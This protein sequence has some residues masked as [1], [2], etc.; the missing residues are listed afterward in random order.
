[1]FA[2]QADV[3]ELERLISQY[4]QIDDDE[5][6]DL[7]DDFV[8]SATLV[9]SCCALL[10]FLLASIICPDPRTY[11]SSMVIQM[12]IEQLQWLLPGQSFL[13]IFCH[14]AAPLIS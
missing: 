2:A 13:T 4:Q 6:G 12:H 1:M 5:Q 10:S 14:P 11:W 7:L 9:R 3:D 8:L